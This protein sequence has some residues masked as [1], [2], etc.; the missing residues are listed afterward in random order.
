MYKP[1]SL[2]K[3]LTTAI[4]EIKRSPEKLHIFITRGAVRSTGANKLGFAYRYTLTLLIEDFGGSPD[5]LTLPVL[6]WLSRHQ[7]Q[8]FAK[9][10]QG[11]DS[12]AFDADI[13]AND[14]ADIE[15]RL[16]LDE[17]VTVKLLPN[18]SYE[19][20]HPEEPVY[21]SPFESVSGDVRLWK[22]FL[23]DELIAEALFPDGPPPIP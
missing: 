3:F 21:D 19:V 14:K 20:D 15:I 13:L 7:P 8:L 22:L 2:R 11:G 23:K 17:T 18:G 16:E 10:L 12:F 1:D 9:A 6:I 4:P 5:K